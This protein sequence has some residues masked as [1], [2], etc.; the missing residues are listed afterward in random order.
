[1]TKVKKNNE[2][3]P[4]LKKPE[5]GSAAI[6][7]ELFKVDSWIDPADLQEMLLPEALHLHHELIATHPH[8]LFVV[9]GDWRLSIAVIVQEASSTLDM[10][11]THHRTKTCQIT[12][13]TL[14]LTFRDNLKLCWYNVHVFWWAGGNQ[15]IWSK[16]MCAYGEHNFSQKDL[17]LG[18]KTE[19]LLRGDRPLLITADHCWPCH[20]L[21][22]LS[23]HTEMFSHPLVFYTF[24]A[25]YKTV[26]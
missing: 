26:S 20:N 9:Q 10:S 13:Y 3:I 6:S 2:N 23:A 5:D 7:T 17:K 4:S 19:M 25:L 12:F 11:Q 18:D 8:S 1:M 15:K 22:N 24:I 14:S 16:S 21:Q